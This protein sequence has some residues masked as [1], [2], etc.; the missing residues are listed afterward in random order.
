MEK[1]TKAKPAKKTVKPKTKKPP[2]V[3]EIA[4][5]EEKD[6]GRPTLY[7]PEYCETL[8]A[9][10]SEGQSVVEVAIAIGVCKDTLYEW[11]KVYP[12]FSDA[13]TRGRQISQAWWEKIGR[14]N[15]FDISEYDAEAKISTQRKF[16]DRL[17]SKNVS[18]RFRKDWTDKIEVEQTGPIEIKHTFD[19][20]G[21]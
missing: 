6:N 11:A 9:M 3:K 20:Q 12:E 5:V 7:K 13:L 1:K 4:I 15:L 2:K 10:F 16:N 8:P 17:W 14:E 18:C 21:I 19:P